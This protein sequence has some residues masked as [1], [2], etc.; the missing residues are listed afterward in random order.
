VDLGIGF[1]DI[2]MAQF[3][4]CHDIKLA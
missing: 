2:G 4:M 1:Q 3:Q